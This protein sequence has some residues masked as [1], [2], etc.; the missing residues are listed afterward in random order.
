M[1][2]SAIQQTDVIRFCGYPARGLSTDPNAGFRYLTHY[3]QLEWR[4][5]NLSP[6]EELR[7][8]GIITDCLALEA[9]IVAASGNLGTARA[10]VWERNPAEVRDR[11]GLLT[12]RRLNL[13][14]MF[15]VPPGPALTGNSGMRLSV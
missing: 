8:V 7:V 2:L 5:L 14:G 15:G 4:M 3:G 9:A 6:S 10:A 13:C 11:V 12:E 1:S